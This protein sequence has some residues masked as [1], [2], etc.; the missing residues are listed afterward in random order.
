MSSLPTIL[1]DR[2]FLVGKLSDKNLQDAIDHAL[3]GVQPGHGKA[4]LTFEMGGV[5]MVFA[6][7]LS[8]NWSIKAVGKVEWDGSH[9]EGE[10]IVQGS[11]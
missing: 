10:V 3:D 8:E 5:H 1:P 4:T 11:W 2:P 6:E 9:P 7:R